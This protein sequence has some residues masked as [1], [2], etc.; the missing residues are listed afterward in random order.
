MNICKM[1]S[2]KPP[3]FSEHFSHSLRLMTDSHVACVHYTSGH[4]Q[5]RAMQNHNGLL[6]SNSKTEICLHKS[7]YEHLL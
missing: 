5:M 1:D 4:Q 7:L 3:I 6:S 2:L